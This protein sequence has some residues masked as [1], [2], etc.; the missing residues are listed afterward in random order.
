MVKIGKLVDELVEIASDYEN[1]RFDQNHVRQWLEQFPEQYH[2]IILSELNYILERTYISKKSS[3]D[4]IDAIINN[5]KVLPDSIG[6]Y[7]FLDIQIAGRSQSDLLDLL[8]E[9]VESTVDLAVTKLDNDYEG[10]FV[11]IDDVFYTG[12]RL[13]RDIENWLNHLSD[14]DDIKKIENLVIVYYFAHTNNLEYRM[15]Q[16]QKLLPYTEITFRIGKKLKNDIKNLSEYD[17]FLPTDKYKF[18][19]QATKY[20]SNIDDLRSDGQKKYIKLTRPEIT[21]NS[22]QFIGNQDNRKILEH[23]F[24]E[25]GVLITDQAVNPS[26]KPMG[27]DYNPSLGF[28]SMVVTYRNAPNNGPLVF[29]WGNEQLDNWYPLFPRLVH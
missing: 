4:Y 2:K 5:E 19:S 26:I 20:I 14:E 17:A 29:W 9:S 7:K 13:Y 16:L 27:Y 11:Y 21:Y 25:E 15:K 18:S 3:Y 24:F 8:I 28:G 12:N 22:S 23:L 6:N 1:C 10:S